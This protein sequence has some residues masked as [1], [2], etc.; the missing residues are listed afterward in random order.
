MTEYNATPDDEHR[1][2]DTD[3]PAAGTPAS[4][5]EHAFAGE[6]MVEHVSERP[7][8][9]D[10]GEEERVPSVTEAEWPGEA[11]A[12][13]EE[14]PADD[15]AAPEEMPED[16]EAGPDTAGPGERPT[17]ADDLTVGHVIDPADA[18]RFHQGW[19][20][21]KAGFV[22]DPSDALDRAG[23]LSAEVVEELTA[24][25]VRIRENLDERSREA[26]G[27]GDT[28]RLRVVLRGYGSLLDHILTR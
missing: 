20:D 21:V 25:L 18:D 3:R 1:N 11:A 19:R 15:E 16:D 7:A 8:E 28:E 10:S 22:D 4:E 26:A 12:A 27:T 13:P 6:P 17:P 24:A 14:A 2:P 23:S 5:D 9:P